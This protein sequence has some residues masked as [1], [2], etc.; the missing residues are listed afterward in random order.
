MD[1][2]ILLDSNPLSMVS[3]PAG[4]PV[5][6]RCRKWMESLLQAGISVRVPE[7]TDYELR[8]VLIY[9]GKNPGIARLDAVIEETGGLLLI[10]NKIM[11][12]A[13]D[14]W[15][16]ARHSGRGKATDQRLDVDV[17]LCAQARAV[18]DDGNDVEIA[19]ENTRDLSKFVKARP[20]YVIKP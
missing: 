12:Q 5:N 6:Q 11:R 17:I 8:R 10:N 1:R 13:A 2:V 20:W 9:N 19:S 7:I 18:F 4:E 16:Q 14:F 3:N 15:S